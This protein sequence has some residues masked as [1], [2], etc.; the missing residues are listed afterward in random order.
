MTGSD[1]GRFQESNRKDC[2][3]TKIGKLYVKLKLRVKK[4]RQRFTPLSFSIVGI[5]FEYA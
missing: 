3:K 1:T 5:L 4:M 2:E